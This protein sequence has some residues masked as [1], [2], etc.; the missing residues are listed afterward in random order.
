[1]QLDDTV[2]QHA[3]FIKHCP[4][5]SNIIHGF[6]GF[7]PQQHIQLFEDIIAKCLQPFEVTLE[8]LEWLHGATEQQPA[9]DDK[10]AQPASGD[11]AAEPASDDEVP[12]TAPKVYTVNQA[13]KLLEW[14]QTGQYYPYWPLRRACKKYSAYYTAVPEAPDCKY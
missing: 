12:H 10:A 4:I 5:I 13:Y 1:M 7:W 11:E 3:D 9:S 2:P 8:N 14:W 6:G